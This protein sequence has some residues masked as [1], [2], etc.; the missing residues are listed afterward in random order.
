[1][2]LHGGTHSLQPK[3]CILGI[4]P[5]MGIG[6]RNKQLKNI[7]SIFKKIAFCLYSLAISQPQISPA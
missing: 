1:M 5:Y 7:M 3:P 2:K 4:D 6:N